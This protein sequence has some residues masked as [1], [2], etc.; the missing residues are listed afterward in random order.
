MSRRNVAA[1]AEQ[2]G[3]K[4]SSAKRGIVAVPNPEP[5]DGDT[6]L[7]VAEGR[8]GQSAFNHP[9]DTRSHRE[10]LK[11]CVKLAD[12]MIPFLPPAFAKTHKK[13]PYWPA[14]SDEAAE[15]M[16]ERD[17]AQLLGENGQQGGLGKKAGQV[18][19]AAAAVMSEL[20]DAMKDPSKRAEAEGC[21]VS[22]MSI[23]QRFE[24]KMQALR[25]GRA[26]LPKNPERAE[27]LRRKRAARKAQRQA[28]KATKKAVPSKIAAAD[29]AAKQAKQEA[30]LFS[31]MDEST[32]KARA[33]IPK[34]PQQALAKV[35]SHK[36][37]LA[38]LPATQREEVERN[39]SW[40]K[41]IQM[42]KGIPVKDNEKLLKASLK[43]HAKA[44]EQRGKKWNERKR[45]QEWRQA[46]AQKERT[47][48]IQQRIDAKKQSRRR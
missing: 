36:Q 4:R 23:K 44:K 39:E 11:E 5:K 15:E 21:R 16:A 46:K 6:G 27:K 38:N 1:A 47:A 43:R 32:R 12:K 3:K 20:G 17:A 19:E 14:Q 48:N 18:F 34:N 28:G 40:A 8:Q 41:A 25:A 33:P 30:M 26:A 45:D 37:K 35:Q 2:K 7:D 29:N 24:V 10:Q 9:G 22:G 13:V 42:T 31:K